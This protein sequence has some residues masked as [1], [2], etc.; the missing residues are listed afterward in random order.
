MIISHKHKF[1]F[2]KTKK[3]AGTSI[4]I[5]LSKICGKEDVISP[6]TKED[7]NF[8]TKYANVSAQNYNIPLNQYSKF[9]LFKS[10]ITR[11]RKIYYNHMPCVE[12]K[13]NITRDIW[14]NYFKFTIERNPFDKIVSLYY[15]RG[16][17]K[18]FKSFY[19]FLVNGGLMGFNSYDIYA[20]DGI[21][22]VDHIY[23]YEDLDSLC[24]SLTKRLGLKNPLTMPAYKAK[25]AT[26]KVKKL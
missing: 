1:I 25:A 12:I 3:T 10:L 2:I 21:I 11:K 15:W 14:D 24:E 18:K 13:E 19:D 4:E 9:D 17:D 8:R 26:R 5:A 7:E 20:I 6:I 16:G 23:Q 22:G